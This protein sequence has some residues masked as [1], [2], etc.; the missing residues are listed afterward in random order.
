MSQY[1]KLFGGTR[2]PFDP[3]DRVVFK[4]ESRHIVVM[5]KDAI[6]K[7][8][9][10]ERGDPI[11]KSILYGMIEAIVAAPFCPATPLGALTTER[12]EQWSATYE[13]MRKGRLYNM[14]F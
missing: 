1:K 6:H 8:D 3:L 2:I 11:Q 7:L 13:I 5:H 4:P 9:V 12:R 10:I 14:R